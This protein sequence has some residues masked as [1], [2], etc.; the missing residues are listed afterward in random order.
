MAKNNGGSQGGGG[1]QNQGGT[2]KPKEGGVKEGFGA[3]STKGSR[4]EDRPDNPKK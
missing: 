1:N 4:S 2:S 3:G